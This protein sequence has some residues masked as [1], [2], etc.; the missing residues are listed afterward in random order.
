MFFILSGVSYNDLR[1][2]NLLWDSETGL[3]VLDFDDAT[4]DNE[5]GFVKDKTYI[6]LLVTPSE[7]LRTAAIEVLSTACCSGESS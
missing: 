7:E 6:R 5:Q 4:F 2:K 1:T 3:W